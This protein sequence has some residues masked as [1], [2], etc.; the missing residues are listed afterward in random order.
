MTDEK[1]KHLEFI[2]NVI[3]R[4]NINSFQI[5][6]WTVIIISALLAIY[7]S[8]KNDYFILASIFPVLV[9]WFLDTYYLTQERRFRGIYNDV[10]GISENP[11][12]LKPFEMRP[13]LYTG[14]KY[15]YWNVFISI[16]IIK[17]YLSLTI[18]LVGL[19]IYFQA[20]R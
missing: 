10:A 17:L 11:K 15:S 19:F 4:M 5:K 2:Q 18:I 6:G 8:T 16:T 1:I 20:G 12:K 14:D 3:T 7:A 9:F 13:D